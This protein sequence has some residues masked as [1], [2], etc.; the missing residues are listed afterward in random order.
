M[1]PRDLKIVAILGAVF[2]VIL[3]IGIIA[4]GSD[5]NPLTPLTKDPNVR[6]DMT[7]EMCDSFHNDMDYTSKAE[8]GMQYV[9]IHFRLVNDSYGPGLDLNPYFVKWTVTASGVIY[10][11]DFDTY[12][13][14]GYHTAEAIM[15]G[16]QVDD[17]RV[18]QI[19]KE[20]GLSDIKVTLEYDEFGK[21]PVLKHDASLIPDA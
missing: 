3:A 18:F 1:D 21:H 4:G 17:V 16:G 9:I 15:E 7:V 19:P 12:S 10:S 2:I 8:G 13:H 14:P 6:Y 5:D 20:L 11:Y